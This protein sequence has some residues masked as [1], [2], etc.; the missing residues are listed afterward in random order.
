MRTASIHACMSVHRVRP[1]NTWCNQG[2]FDRSRTMSTSSTSR[3]G[4]AIHSERRPPRMQGWKATSKPDAMGLETNFR[5]GADG[6]R[7]TCGCCDS[8]GPQPLLPSPDSG[9]WTINDESTPA[10]SGPPRHVP[11]PTCSPLSEPPVGVAPHEEH[12]IKDAP[13]SLRT[14]QDSARKPEPSGLPCGPSCSRPPRRRRMNDST[15]QTL[16]PSPQEL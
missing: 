9:C 7:K 10:T 15:W 16:P 8:K 2:S 6:R 14:R 12:H 3:V 1:D 4:S 11:A 13:R 5:F